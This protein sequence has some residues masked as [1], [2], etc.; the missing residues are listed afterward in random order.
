MTSLKDFG[1]GKKAS[2]EKIIEESQHLMEVFKEKDGKTKFGMFGFA[3]IKIFL[4]DRALTNLPV[5]YAV[6]TELK[7]MTQSFNSGEL[8]QRNHFTFSLLGKPFD[9]T[10][11]VRFAVSN[12][13]SNI[14]YGNRFEYDDPD[15][16]SM[17]ER[18][19]KNTE[20]MGCASVQVMIYS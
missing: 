12:V 19:C 11:P 7:L 15:F 14:V 17:V 20:L 10:Q 4:W 18:A 8:S 1:M 9:T 16:R 3:K 6:R 2:E 5:N 13:I